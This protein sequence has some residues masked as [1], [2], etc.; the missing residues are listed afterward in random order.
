MSFLISRP[1]RSSARKTQWEK[2]SKIG[3]RGVQSKDRTHSKQF[4]ITTKPQN[5]VKIYFLL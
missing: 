1:R 2:E 3:S 5:I 4:G